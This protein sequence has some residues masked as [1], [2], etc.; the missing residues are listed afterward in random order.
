VDLIC[1][2]VIRLVAEMMAAS[3]RTKAV[4][5][6]VCGSSVNPTMNEMVVEAIRRNK[7]PTGMILI[8]VRL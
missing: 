5:R 8:Y 6:R 7:D 4:Q 2:Q 1:V 3:C